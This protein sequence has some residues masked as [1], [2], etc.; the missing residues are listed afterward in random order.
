MKIPLLLV[1]FKKKE[2][3]RQDSKTYYIMG[4]Q[5]PIYDPLSP[6]EW[7]G[8]NLAPHFSADLRS[9]MRS[10]IPS[11]CFKSPCKAPTSKVKYRTFPFCLEY[12][13][14]L[15]QTKRPSCLNFIPIAASQMF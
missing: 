4:F 2:I 6:P 13:A 9:E 10:L 11:G 5:Y 15:D 3:I 14:V 7:E 12:T 8:P 1:F